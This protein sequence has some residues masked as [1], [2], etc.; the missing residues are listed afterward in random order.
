MDIFNSDNGNGYLKKR[1]GVSTFFFINGFASANWVARLPELQKFYR[2]DNTNLGLLLLISAVGALIFMPISGILSRKSGSDKVTRTAGLSFCLLIP[3]LS[4]FEDFF[5]IALIFFLYGCIL[6]VLNVAMNTQAVAVERLIQ[7]PVM[8]SFH[9]LFSIGMALGA[10][11]GAFFAKFRFSLTAHLGLISFFGLLLLLRGCFHLV[12]KKERRN[13][14]IE[15]DNLNFLGRLFLILPLGVIAF[16]GMTGEN[17][18]VDWSAIYMNKV[19]QLDEATSA[20]AFGAYATAMTIGRLFGDKATQRMGRERLLKANAYLAIFGMLVIIVPSWPFVPFFGFFLVGLGLANI[21]P[22]TYSRA[23]NVKGVES[24]SGV[25]MASTIGYTGF[26][27]GPPVI[28][29]LGDIYGLRI[30]FAFTLS[31][32]ILM[33]M[34]IHLFFKKN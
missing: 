16:C 30:A 19:I 25:A 10:L 14:N 24:S 23:G 34:L 31:L 21:A 18:M 15:K 5:W 6:G 1:L 17:N 2:V 29:Y 28:G 22:I 8:S 20:L 4:L 3:F 13:D 27:I 11:T 12:Q 32:F 7:K 9:A 33:L 26:F